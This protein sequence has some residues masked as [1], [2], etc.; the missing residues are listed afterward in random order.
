[1]TQAQWGKTSRMNDSRGVGKAGVA[2]EPLAAK[3]FSQ[4]TEKLPRL[5]LNPT[6]ARPL[7]MFPS[8]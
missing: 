2:V 1:L 4:I 5:L 3:D 6:L 7:A 8:I